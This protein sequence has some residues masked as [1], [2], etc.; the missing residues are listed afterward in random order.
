MSQHFLFYFKDC[1]SA[2]I[3]FIVEIELKRENSGGDMWHVVPC[4]IRHNISMAA[5][6]ITF[7]YSEIVFF[8]TD[9]T[10]EALLAFTFFNHFSEFTHMA[11]I[12]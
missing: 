2:T 4:R 12:Y 10:L 6:L 11:Y 7:N 1:F 3:A 9:A 8:L 5:H